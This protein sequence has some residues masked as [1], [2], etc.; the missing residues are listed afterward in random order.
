MTIHCHSFTTKLGRVLCASTERGVCRICL[1]GT[2]R[3]AFLDQVR[4]LSAG[5]DP[6][7]ASQVDRCLEGEVE[8]Y[9]DGKRRIFTVPLDLRVTD[10]AAS[11]L[12][13]VASIPY[14]ATR[15]YGQI[16]RALNRPGAARAVGMANAHNPLPL[17]IPC[18][19]VVAADGLGGYGGGFDMK[20]HLL[21][22]EQ[23]ASSEVIRPCQAAQAGHTNRHS[24]DI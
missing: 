15:T 8:E 17:V 2:S 1:P 23:A 21:A 11:V 12:H 10:F 18:H 20:R 22:L 13:D 9:L 5:A 7:P 24:A 16:A 19:R 4:R 14:G 6:G 3:Q